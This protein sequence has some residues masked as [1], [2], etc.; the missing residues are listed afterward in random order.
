MVAMGP[1]DGRPPVVKRLSV[2]LR[3]FGA[4]GLRK[5]VRPQYRLV[6]SEAAEVRISIARRAG[7][8]FRPVTSLARSMPPGANHL[9]YGG[10]AGG[11]R[12]GRYRARIGVRMGA[13]A[14]HAKRA[15]PHEDPTCTG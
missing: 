5:A 10:R 3:D 12:S 15:W 4:P 13:P 14:F 1:A 2:R 8:R 11:L 7:G 9:T 6:L